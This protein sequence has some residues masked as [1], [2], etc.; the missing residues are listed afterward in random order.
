MKISV[1]ADLFHAAGWTDRQTDITKLMVAFRNLANT[2][3]N[4]VLLQKAR[5]RT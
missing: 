5:S 2:P 4:R 1:G 3:S